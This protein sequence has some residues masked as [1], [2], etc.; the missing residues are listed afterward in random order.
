MRRAALLS[1]IAGVCLVGLRGQSL[2]RELFA[3]DNAT[4]RDQKLSFEQQADL[5]SRTGYAGLGLYTSTARLP[6]MLRALDGRKLPL[7][8]VYVHAFVDESGPRIDPHLPEVIRQLAGRKAMIMLTLRG[9]AQDDTAA[10]SLV[11][12]IADAASGLRVCLYPH[13]NF[14]VETAADGLRVL[15]KAGRKNTG[16]AFNLT[17]EWNYHRRSGKPGQPDWSAL[18]R[19]AAPHILM[20]SINGAGEGSNGQTTILRLDRSELDVLPFVRAL[21]EARYRGPISLQAVGVSGDVEENLREA[22]AAWRRLR[23][24]VRPR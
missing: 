16:V 9:K 1:L 20:A 14:F 12:D 21:N 18:L 5:L 11:R 10:V 6:E 23:A 15:R 7:L 13:L 22:M 24:R 4:G 3:F 19:E 17:H 8:A 2:S